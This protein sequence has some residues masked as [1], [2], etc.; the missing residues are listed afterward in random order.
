[1]VSPRAALDAKE[2]A[3]EAA[4]ASL[5]GID[6]AATSQLVQAIAASERAEAAR[7]SARLY[8]HPLIKSLSYAGRIFPGKRR[9]AMPS[10][11]PS[12]TFALGLLDLIAPSEAGGPDTVAEVRKA[13]LRLPDPMRRP[14]LILINQTGDDMDRL[15]RE[16]Q[17]W[18]EDAME[19]LTGLYKRKAQLIVVII[20]FVV[21]IGTNADTIR[22]VRELSNNSALREAVVA[23]AQALANET[24]DELRT[25]LDRERAART[26]QP[27]TAQDSPGTTVADTM[28][29]LRLKSIRASVDSLKTIGLPLGWRPLPDSLRALLPKNRA[30]ARA[31]ADTAAGTAAGTAASPS[32]RAADPTRAPGAANQLPGALEI[33]AGYYGGQLWRGAFGLLMTVFALSLGAPFWF[34]MLNKVVNIRAAGRA[35]EE[36]P[37]PPEALPPARGA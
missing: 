21:T 8:Q 24:P 14:L 1:V 30:K 33:Y 22:I 34:D 12:R 31:A 25:L 27:T 6:D 36:K 16:I 10:Y 35:P 37:K 28:A 9:V 32:M 23:H 20:A 5:R 18:Y 2:S 7:Y 19:R 15:Q 29:A 17:R 11:I 26:P 13:A 4:L 3:Y